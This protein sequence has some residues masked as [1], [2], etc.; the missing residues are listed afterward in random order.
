M[1]TFAFAIALPDLDFKV[2]VYFLVLV[3]ALNVFFLAVILVASLV[4]LTVAILLTALYA[5]SP[6]N[7]IVAFKDPVLVAFKVT[8]AAPFALVVAL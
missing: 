6:V 3:L 4:I 8:V 7:L 2:T 5:E 1:V